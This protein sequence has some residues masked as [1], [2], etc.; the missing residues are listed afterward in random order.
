MEL[1]KQL[2]FEV[3]KEDIT[4]PQW[5]QEQVRQSKREI[6]DGTA[7]LTEWKSLKKDLFEK[8]NVK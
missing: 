3:I 1:V 4:I 6:K 7:E 8:Y 5:Q 2:G